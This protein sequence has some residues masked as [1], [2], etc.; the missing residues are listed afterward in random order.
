MAGLF[1]GGGTP[2][3]PPPPKPVAPMPDEESPLVL[4]A[5]RRKQV[6]ILNRSGRRSTIMSQDDS[7]APYSAKTLGG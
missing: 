5:A 1:G 6:E 4:E 2:P 7:D 3:P